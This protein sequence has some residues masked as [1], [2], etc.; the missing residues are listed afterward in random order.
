MVQ[1]PLAQDSMTNDFSLQVLC[2]EQPQKPENTG[3]TEYVHIRKNCFII[4]TIRKKST[5]KVSRM[6]V[7]FFGH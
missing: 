6:K 2:V 3:D 1:D 4:Y 5:R 7:K